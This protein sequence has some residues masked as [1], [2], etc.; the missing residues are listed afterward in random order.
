MFKH[1]RLGA[2]IVLIAACGDPIGTACQFEGSGFTASDNCRYRCLEYRAISCPDGTQIQGPK[3]C[4]G[5]QQCEPGS[6]PSGQT[7]YHVPD[8]F[9]K[10]SYCLPAD[11]CGELSSH[12][13]GLWEKESKA[14]SDELV[15][16]WE[17]KQARRQNQVTSPAAVNEGGNQ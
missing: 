15:A 17:T 13:I 5:A 2:C 4:S 9:E 12:A 8:P 10:E 7:C 16:E 6:C 1:F 3:I 14:V 11:I